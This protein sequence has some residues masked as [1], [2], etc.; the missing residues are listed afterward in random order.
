MM[1][2][3]DTKAVLDKTQN[4]HTRTTESIGTRHRM[5]TPEPQALLGQDT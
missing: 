3:S 4:E 5:N 1:D 2:K